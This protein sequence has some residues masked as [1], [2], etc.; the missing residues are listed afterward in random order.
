VVEAVFTDGADEALGERVR[1]G[2]RTGVRIAS[3]PLALT[4]SSNDAVNFCPGLERGD[5]TV[6]WCL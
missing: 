5:G 1:L 4:T 2:D 6:V 3:I